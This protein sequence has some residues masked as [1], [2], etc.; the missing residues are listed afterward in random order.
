MNEIRFF[1]ITAVRE[2]ARGTVLEGDDAL[3]SGAIIDPARFAGVP[4]R[5][6]LPGAAEAHV[7]C[8]QLDVLDQSGVRRLVFELETRIPNARP[9]GTV[10]IDGALL[11]P[12]RGPSTRGSA[13][14]S[15][16]SISRSE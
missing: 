3:L 1:R 6:Q 10:W 7:A 2:G 12:P 14:R 4:A 9:G 8:A 5:L 15:G 13:T 11:A 16:R